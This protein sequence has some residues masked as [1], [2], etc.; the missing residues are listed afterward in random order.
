[1]ENLDKFEKIADDQLLTINGGYWYNIWA[2][3]PGEYQRNSVTGEYRWI[4]TQD[5][6]SYTFSVIGNGWGSAG[7]PSIGPG[8]DGSY[9]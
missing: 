1:M 8:S 4:Q 6:T 9:Y 3:G 5:Y 7:A 2:V